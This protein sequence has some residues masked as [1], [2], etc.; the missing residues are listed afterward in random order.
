MNQREYFPDG[1]PISDWFYDTSVP[2]LSDLGKQYVIT[3]HGI[4][5][6][7]NIYTEKFQELIDVI[8]SNGGGVMVVPKGTYRTGAIFFKQ[9]VHLYLE[10]DGVIMGSDDISDYPVCETRIEGE[11]CKYFP[12]LINADGIDGFTITGEGTIDGNGHR[13]WRAFWLRVKWNPGRTGK[14]EQRARL[15]FISNSKN[16]I[17]SGVNLQNS[18]FWTS[19][20]YKCERVKFLGCRIFSPKTPVAAPSTDAIDVDVCTDVLI[21]NCYMEVNDDAVALKGGKGPYADTQPENGS[22]ERILIEDCACGFCHSCLT[23][24]SE[25]IHNRNVIFRRI[26]VDSAILFRMKMRP[27]TPQHYEYIRV[28]DV[29][30]KVKYFIDV[31]PW[32]QYFDLKGR[33]DVPMSYADNITIRNCDCECD[34]YFNVLTDDSQYV[35]SD[36]VLENLNITALKNGYTDSAIKNAT[37]SNVNVTVKE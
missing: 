30:G 37:L 3:D 31:N 25:S 22:N 20:I 23:C 35:L 12:A 1:T 11:S 32:R 14:D 13:S 34:T 16:V 2:A 26:T 36:F 19:H 10:K 4:A 15:V 17:I 6:D 24:G 27:D 18:H 33:P 28:E 21:K 9:G 8:A 7:G 29:K 5:D